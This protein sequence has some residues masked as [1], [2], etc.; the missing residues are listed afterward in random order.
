MELV[1]VIWVVNFFF[2]ALI[3]LFVWSKALLADGRMKAIA[4]LVEQIESL[5]AQMHP[6]G[7][8]A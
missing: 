4:S 7:E 3:V 1:R 2:F 5:R 8:G 6:P